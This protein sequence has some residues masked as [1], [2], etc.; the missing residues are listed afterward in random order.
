MG[1]RYCED[2]HVAEVVDAGS[3]VLDGVRHYALDPERA[4]ALWAKSEELVGERFA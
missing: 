4:K 1:A 3:N 2:C